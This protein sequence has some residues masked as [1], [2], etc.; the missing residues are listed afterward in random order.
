MA[1]SSGNSRSVTSIDISLI[2]PIV[3]E[4]DAVADAI[5]SAINGVNLEVGVIENDE[6]H[7][8]LAPRGACARRFSIDFSRDRASILVY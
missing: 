8:S 3:E 1:E 4:P 2:S 5:A 7:D 6:A